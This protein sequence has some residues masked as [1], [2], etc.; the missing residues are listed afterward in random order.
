MSIW[1]IIP[2]K[3][4]NRAKS[5][6]AQV[7]SPQDREQLAEL[8]LRHV[9]GVVRN[10]PQIQGTLVI[11][12][13]GRALA[14]AREFGAR[15]VQ[16]SGAPELNNALMRA[17]QV[18]T[19][20]NTEA[21]LILPAD[22]PLINEDDLNAILDLGHYNQTVVIATDQSEDGTNA[23]FIRPPGVIDYAYGPGSFQRHIELA[24][25]AGA[26][27]K[28]YQSPRMLLDIDLP[29]D[30]EIYRELAKASEIV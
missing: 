11:S 4:L 2:V 27:V 7:L 17:T 19:R 3:P 22:L 6:L 10:I 21:V 9:L 13:D 25:E 28:V 16:E 29:A 12:R 14:I 20:W 18:A 15:T 23:L 8:M 24:Q 1:A 5:R 30:L 26:D